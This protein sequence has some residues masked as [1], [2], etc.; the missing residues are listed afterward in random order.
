M[1]EVLVYDVLA[2]ALRGNAAALRSRRLLQ[3]AG[4]RGDKIFPPTFAGATYM[5][6]KRRIPDHVEP[7][8]CVVLDTVQSQANRMEAALQEGVDAEDIS[9]PLL[10][11]D[12]SAFAPTGDLD[13]DAA[14][15]RFLDN[16]GRITSLEVPHRLADAILRDSEW[17]GTLFRRSEKGRLLNVASP[18]N[19]TPVFELG[20]TALIFGMWDSTGPKG[21]LGAKFERVIVSEVVGVDASL[22]PTH[23]S[24]GV[25]RDPLEASKGIAIVEEP[26]GAWHV[27]EGNV[28]GAAAP[29]NINHGSVPLDSE[30]AGVTVD[31]AEQ[32][33]T[34]SLIGLRRLKFP[35]AGGVSREANIAAQ[36]TLAA[37]ALYASAR[38]FEDG[39]DLRS[40]CVLW[41]EVPIIWE[42]LERPGSTPSRFMLGHHEARELL[43]HAIEEAR[44]HGL[45]WHT[46][47][48]MLTPSAQLVD[49]VR[50]SQQVRVSSPDGD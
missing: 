27:A 4:G 14:A 11:V 37:L 3:P 5:I 2:E 41:P 7:V 33:T 36:A 1:D 45:P 23:R 47:P 42:L 49:L 44:H 30:N 40:R 6:E 25:R 24:R 48:V 28:R 43:R 29:S 31:Y 35:L 9:V 39:M 12:F 19:A 17:N 38:A 32:T 46:E 13:A 10:V 15:G 18:A 22:D 50:R 21:G 20:P 8:T 16:V 26:D 34:L